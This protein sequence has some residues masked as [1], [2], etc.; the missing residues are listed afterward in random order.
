MVFAATQMTLEMVLLK[1]VS[2]TEEDKYHIMSLINEIYKKGGRNK[3]IYKTEIES[4][5]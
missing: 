5:T 4:Q 2:Q 1:E 3:L